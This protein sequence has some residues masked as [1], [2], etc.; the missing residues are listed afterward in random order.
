MKT[1]TVSANETAVVY[2]ILHDTNIRGLKLTS[3]D[4][5]KRLAD[6]QPDTAKR[7]ALFG[8]VLYLKTGDDKYSH[9]QLQLF[10]KYAP[11]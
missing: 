6:V 10:P 3:S 8:W 7:N 5:D 4:V 1:F 9:P 11:R 2:R